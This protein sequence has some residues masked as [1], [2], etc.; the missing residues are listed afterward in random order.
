MRCNPVPLLFL[1]S[2]VFLSSAGTLPAMAQETPADNPPESVNPP[3]KN[4]DETADTKPAPADHPPVEVIPSPGNLSDP[5][6]LEAFFDG[7]LAVQL[8]EKHI[9][10]AVVA[11]VVGDQLV[12]SKGY[13]Y[14]DI[15]AR[16]QVDPQK[17]LFRIASISKLFTWTAVMQQ[18]EEGKLDLDTDVNT[19]L[20]DVQI[21]AAFDKPVTLKDLMTHT[22]G[23][24]DV[25]IGVFARKAES[26]HPL[27]E[28]LRG[29][30]PTRVRPPG[31]LAS[32]SNA[33][34]GLAGLAVAGVSG[35]TWEDYVE[36]RLLKPLDMQHTLVRQP[37]E[38]DLPPEMS[39]G[40]KWTGGRYKTEEFEYIPAAPAGSISTTAADAAKFML[41]HLHDGRLGEQ[42]ILKPETAQLMRQPLFRH[43]PKASPMCYGFWEQ[44]WNGMKIV[45]H[46][47]DTLW[48]H[49]LMQLIPEKKVG[50][51]VSYNTETSGG[52]RELLFRAF[53]RRYFPAPTPPRI[54]PL[55]GFA[56]RA[57]K[58]AG[59]YGNTRYSHTS[60]TKL[61]ALTSVSKVS[62]NDDDET[63]TVKF[64][65]HSRR[66]LEVEPYVFRSLD[67]P[68][69]I[70]FQKN[71]DG[72]VA[73]MF[74]VDAAAV[75]AVR[76]RWYELT[77][78]QWG[79]LIGSATIF[80]SA[81]LFWPVIAYFRR[82]GNFPHVKRN[83]RSALFSG[84]GWLLSLASLVLT[85]GLAQALADPNEIIFG[86][87]DTMKILL[88]IPQVCA[89]LAVLTV[90]GGLIAWQQG[91][92]TLAGRFHYT[93]VALA[94]VGFIW[95]LSYWN[96]LSF[97]WKV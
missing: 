3:E 7:A 66:L 64:G 12:F 71:K 15:D 62:V 30:M 25:V 96:L 13:G 84:F 82:G 65:E 36:Q 35:M 5:H 9:A 55:E 26:I 4:A 46:G 50:V 43:D 60:P 31:Q 37:A 90:L 33:G 10:G 92:W 88:A 11:V 48:F 23:F 34:T 21:P 22:P 16:R 41:A 63:I 75:A 76:L 28:V 81:L 44:E 27:A 18:V 6:D 40:Y 67:G 29:E 85:A 95:F 42:Q 59:E 39:K 72:E 14:A 93:L 51:F 61:A 83:G 80:A 57:K 79:L 2:A 8:Q 45:G 19:Y 58:I 54:K 47:G 1:M 32:Y 91:Y 24:D 49:S 97:G 53:L 38:K 86:L 70:V 87:S 89:F 17:T 73:Y 52:Q 68:E 78:V 74:P 94:G 56:E 20:K 77:E 69:K